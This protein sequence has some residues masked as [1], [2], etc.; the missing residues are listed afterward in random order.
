M[1]TYKYST[2][3][4]AER[5][6]K[7]L[8]CSGSH[9]HNEDG[10]KIYM[11]CKDMK[12]FKEKTKKGKE[13]EV[14]ELVDAD[15]TWL[16]SNQPILDP[17]STLK[18]STITDKIV[19]MS[20]NPRDPLLR[21]WYGYYG[22]SVVKE[23]DM[24]DAFG[25]ED[26]KFMDYKDTV[27]HYEKKLGLDKEDAEDRA[28]QQGKGPKL[29]KKAP[30]KIKDK[31]NFIDRLILKEKGIDENLDE[32]VLLDKESDN[33][34]IKIKKEDIN[35]L[36]LRNIRSIKK[37]AKQHGLTVQELIKLLKDEQ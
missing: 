29:V 24:E 27:K 30:K 5:V 11:P 14:T 2:K 28:K 26:T 18:G 31:K 22:E 12:I 20:R 9:Y 17:A 25:F 32:D 35:P 1:K 3:E 8:G 19:P 6:A 7:S 15:G 33:K 13:E 21:G 16:S 34:D 37:M 10:K 36:L 4:R 23:E